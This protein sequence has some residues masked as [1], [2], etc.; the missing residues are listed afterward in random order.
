MDVPAS[1]TYRIEA[2]G[3]EGG[4]GSAQ[5]GGAGA[6]IIGELICLV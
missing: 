3:A 5:S 1:G 4:Q 6:K 2:F